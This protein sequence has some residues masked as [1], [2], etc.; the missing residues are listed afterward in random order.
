MDTADQSRSLVVTTNLFV[1]LTDSLFKGS[2]SRRSAASLKDGKLFY[3]LTSFFVLSLG[4]E[5]FK[6][7]I[8][9]KQTVVLQLTSS[10]SR[11]IM[12]TAGS[13][14]LDCQ[15]HLSEG[16]EGEHWNAALSNCL[17]C[18]SCNMNQSSQD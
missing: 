7:S 18:F 2:K 9:S 15:I 10:L 17:F 3:H 14:S 8:L 11:F 13:A 6:G 4:S 16:A 12:M 5:I 1:F